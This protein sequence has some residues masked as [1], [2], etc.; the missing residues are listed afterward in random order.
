MKWIILL[1]AFWNCDYKSSDDEE[2]NR[3]LAG[4][5][6]SRVS[7]GSTSSTTSSSITCSSSSPSFSTLASAGVNTNCAR[8]GCHDGT[9]QQSGFNATSYSS[10]LARVVVRN[11]NSS[12][13]YTKVSTGSMAQYSNSTINTAIFCWIQGG[14]NQ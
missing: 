12:L 14:A 1:L 7:G 6:L 3:I 8:S 10:S 11:P 5:L 4:V 9:T 2:R 13:L